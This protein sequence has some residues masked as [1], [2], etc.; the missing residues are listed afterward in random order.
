MRQKHRKQ[1]WLSCMAERYRHTHVQRYRMS[2]TRFKEMTSNI[3][4]VDNIVRW[5][6]HAFL[7]LSFSAAPYKGISKAVGILVPFPV[8]IP[9]NIIIYI[10]SRQVIVIL[11]ETSI[12]PSQNYVCAFCVPIEKSYF[13]F[14]LNQVT[15]WWCC[16]QLK[17]KNQM[18]MGQTPTVWIIPWMKKETDKTS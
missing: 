14:N 10:A 3:P 8:A 2:Q 9:S 5:M 4:N 15:S 13:N 11:P 1:Q 17:Y 12:S 6:M 16:A 18:K 7:V